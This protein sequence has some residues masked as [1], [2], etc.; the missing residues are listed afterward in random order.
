MLN[1]CDYEVGQKKSKKLTGLT[2]AKFE[3]EQN[4]VNVRIMMK[5]NG[6]DDIPLI[7]SDVT[8]AKRNMSYIILGTPDL[9]KGSSKIN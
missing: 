8:V 6:S 5:V 7:L 3:T 2:G 1:F 9:R 4:L